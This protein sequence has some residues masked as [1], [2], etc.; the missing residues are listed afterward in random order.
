MVEDSLLVNNV[1]EG[2]EMENLSRDEIVDDVEEDDYGVV[3]NRRRIPYLAR[4]PSMSSTDN[5]LRDGRVALFKGRRRRSQL[6]GTCIAR[7]GHKR[8]LM[9]GS[10]KGV[11]PY[12]LRFLSL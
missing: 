7:W 8:L 9:F 1:G 12:D 3:E 6:D 2:P 5:M 10:L 11:I 4:H